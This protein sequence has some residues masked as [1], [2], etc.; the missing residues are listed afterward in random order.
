MWTPYKKS[1]YTQNKEYA[2]SHYL[3]VYAELCSCCGYPYG[4]HY[5][6]ECPQAEKIYPTGY[7]TEFY[8][9]KLNNNIKVL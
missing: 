4:Q 2:N 9:E 5:G 1:R 3:R 8:A 6:T 7:P